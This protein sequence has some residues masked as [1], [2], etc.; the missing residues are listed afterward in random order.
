MLIPGRRT[1]LITPFAAL[2]MAMAGTPAM[3]ASNAQSSG[4]KPDLTSTD[5]GAKPAGAG[6]G[7]RIR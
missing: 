1:L 3:A 7:R 6:T 2:A 5:R 4:K